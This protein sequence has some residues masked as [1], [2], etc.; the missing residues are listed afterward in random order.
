VTGKTVKDA[1]EQYIFFKNGKEVNLTLS[2][3]T[4]ADNVDPWKLVSNSV[5]VQ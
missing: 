3:P 2:G 4:T 5:T 1:V